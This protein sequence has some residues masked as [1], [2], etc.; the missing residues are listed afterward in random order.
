MPVGWA[1]L[2]I[3]FHFTVVSSYLACKDQVF[4]WTF[5]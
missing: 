2:P 5:S 3:D 1:L 4:S